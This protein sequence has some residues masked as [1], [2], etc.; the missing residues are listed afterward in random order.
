M[1]YR[2]VVFIRNEETH[3]LTIHPNSGNAWYGT[4][5]FD[6]YEKVM[7]YV[8]PFLTDANITVHI[9]TQNN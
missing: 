9:E 7:E 6:S 4:N 3:A 1:T 5:W 8:T 2:V